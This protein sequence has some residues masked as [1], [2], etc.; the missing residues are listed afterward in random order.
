MTANAVP[1][2]RVACGAGMRAGEKCWEERRFKSDKR[3]D[4][5]GG[6]ERGKERRGGERGRGKYGDRRQKKKE[7]REEI[8]RR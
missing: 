3:R 4:H 7:I 1:L 5:R 2:F 6:H 8:M